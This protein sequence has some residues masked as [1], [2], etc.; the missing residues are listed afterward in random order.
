MVQ[1]QEKKNKI[2]QK[3]VHLRK[4]NKETQ[5]DLAKWINVDRRKIIK[6]EKGNFDLDL[7]CKILNWYGEELYLF[8]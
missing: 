6:L 7:S 3:C 5:S 8:S 4:E 1:L 2:I